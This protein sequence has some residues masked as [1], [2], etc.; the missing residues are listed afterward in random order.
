MLTGDPPLKHLEPHAAMY[1]IGEKLREIV[2]ELPGSTEE[3]RD[4]V[5]AALIRLVLLCYLQ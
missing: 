4:F 5:R 3:A 1:H 2:V